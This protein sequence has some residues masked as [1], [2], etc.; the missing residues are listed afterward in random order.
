MAF[1]RKKPTL[2]LEYDQVIDYKDLVLMTK[3]IGSQGEMVSR[4]RTG[5]DAK[6]QRKLKQAIKR[7]RHIALIPFVV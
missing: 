4:R 1:E 7:A 5:L 6:G 2:D 3:C